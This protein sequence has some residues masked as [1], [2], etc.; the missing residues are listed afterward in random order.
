MRAEDAFLD[1]LSLFLLFPFLKGLSLLF[2][3][4]FQGLETVAGSFL[5]CLSPIKCS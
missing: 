5:F 4:A 2:I 1:F 3:Q